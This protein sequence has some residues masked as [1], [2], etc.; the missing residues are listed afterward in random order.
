MSADDDGGSTSPATNAAGFELIWPGKYDAKGRKVVPPSRRSQLITNQEGDDRGLLVLGDCLDVA[1]ALLPRYRGTIDLIYIDPPFSTGTRFACERQVGSDGAAKIRLPG[2][3]DRWRG[4]AAGFLSM[5][6]PRLRAMHELLAP[7]GSLYLHLDPTLGHAVRLVL[8]EVFGPASFQREIIWRIGWISGYKS[9]ARNWIRNHDSIFFYTKDPKNFTFNKLYVPHREGYKRRGDAG[10]QGGLPLEDVWNAN[11]AEFALEGRASLDSIQIK[12]LSRE[13]SGWATQKNESLLERI[14]LASTN[15]GDLVADFF[16]G[17]ATTAVVAADLDRRFIVADASP[18]A[19]Q[20]ARHRLSL[21]DSPEGRAARWY[22]E[23]SV[24]PGESDATTL[25]RW[26]RSLEEAL[27]PEADDVVCASESMNESGAAAKKK[28]KGRIGRLFCLFGPDQIVGEAEIC[29]A[30]LAAQ[31]QMKA[32]CVVVA[33][34]FAPLSFERCADPALIRISVHTSNWESSEIQTLA[35]VL[36]HIVLQ[37][38]VESG[39]RWSIEVVSCT[40][41]KGGRLTPWPDRGVDGI[42]GYR[43]LDPKTRK[44]VG[45]QIRGQKERSLAQQVPVPD[46]DELILRIDDISGASQ[47]LLVKR[48]V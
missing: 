23:S 31:T 19:L 21:P 33:H 8:D 43:V 44:V 34:H 4:G 14:L 30:L 47:D 1:Q 39:K 46:M 2:F 37:R 9:M 26:R 28:T 29:Q 36:P 12:S 25:E 18:L 5:L 48:P 38:K 45:A 22:Q 10:K 42:E 15:P 41:P 17:S 13:K 6:E 27:S 24:A 20:I 11:D 32:T 3:N 40:W 7:N 16:C 35:L